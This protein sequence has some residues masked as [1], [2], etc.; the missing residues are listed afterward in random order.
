MTSRRRWL[1]LRLGLRLRLHSRRLLLLLLLRCSW[2]LLLLLW[3]FI[4]CGWLG[5]AEWLPLGPWLR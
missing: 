4:C 1:L 5:V 3:W 2:L